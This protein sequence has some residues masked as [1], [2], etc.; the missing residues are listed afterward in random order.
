M[1]NHT[2][3]YTEYKM[4][5]RITICSNLFIAQNLYA[6]ISTTVDRPSQNIS[7]GKTGIRISLI[8]PDG[9]GSMFLSS[10]RTYLTAYTAPHY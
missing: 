8:Y 9:T 2:H 6:N 1:L 5:K 7:G 3:T 10:V 4:F